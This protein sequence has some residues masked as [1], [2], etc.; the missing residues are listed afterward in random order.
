MDFGRPRLAQHSDQCALRV[1]PDD[2]IVDDD[3]PLAV[4]YLAHRVELEADPALAR[5]LGRL[6]EGAPDVGVLDQSLPVG[7]ARGL[8]VAD[9]RGSARVGGRDDQIGVHRTLRGEDAPHLQAGRID[10]AP[11]DRRVGPGEVDVLEDAS[12]GAGLGPPQGAHAAGV[13]DQELAGGDFAHEVRTDDVQGRRLRGDGPSPLQSAEDE[14]AEAVAVAGGVERRLVHEGQRERPFQA[15][16]EREG[17]VLET[18]GVH[19]AQ[20]RRHDGSV[21]RRAAAELPAQ[22]VPR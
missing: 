22:V 19:G 1:P 2:R 18:G 8:G 7:Y 15:R 4:D 17:G 14:R 16:Q 13:D 20:E 5:Q 10:R 9:G 12:R 11:A 21:G 6:D 3:E